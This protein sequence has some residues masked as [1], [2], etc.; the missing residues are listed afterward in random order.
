MPLGPALPR[1]RAVDQIGSTYAEGRVRI[2][3]LVADLPPEAGEAP[4]PTCPGWSVHDVVAHL[5]GSCADVLAGRTDGIT[6]A[7]WADAQVAAR[8]GRPMSTLVEEWTGAASRLEAAAD[9]YPPALG[10]VWILDLTA[11]EHDIRTALG[12]PGARDARGVDVGLTLLVGEAFHAA[13]S[14]RSLGPV[15]MRTPDR[16]WTVGANA[17]DAPPKAVVEAS[18]FELFRCL[19]GRRSRAQIAALAWSV[20][21]EPYLDAFQFATFT[22]SGVDIEE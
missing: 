8:R 21:P 3:E 7:A 13:L 20:D 5:A 9:R 1:F 18:A 12:R 17:A 10:V 19:T 15:A 2:L 4:V 6:T 16:S 14:A 11:H 22:T